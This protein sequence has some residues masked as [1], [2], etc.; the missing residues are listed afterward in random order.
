VTS[1]YSRGHAGPYVTTRYSRGHAAPYIT[2]RYSRGSDLR[3]TQSRWYYRTRRLGRYNRP[4]Y[5]YGRDSRYYFS[6]G[7]WLP[8]PPGYIYSPGAG[9]AFQYGRWV[10]AYPVFV[11]V[12]AAYDYYY[13]GGWHEELPPYFVEQEMIVPPVAPEEEI[14][15]TPTAEPEPAPEYISVMTK[16]ELEFVLITRTY[17]LDWWQAKR[18]EDLISKQIIQSVLAG[19]EAGENGRIVFDKRK[20][21]MTITGTPDDVL[22]IRTIVDD[23]RTYKLFTQEDLGDLAV[24]AVPLVDLRFLENDPSGALRIA[25]D[26]YSGADELLRASED[27]PSGRE[28]WF[29][30]RIG[31][32][33]VRNSVQNL[34]AVYEFLETSPYLR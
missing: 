4:Y 6:N 16:A 9:Y 5:Y 18:V 26:N 23:D 34:D 11:P 19:G 28:W 15:V 14:I 10:A 1:R 29:N 13:D 17:D 21:K 7:R 31:T 32:M 2:P 27:T 12:P 3:P 8:F 25:T 24:D 22:R 20:Q 33:T 30:D